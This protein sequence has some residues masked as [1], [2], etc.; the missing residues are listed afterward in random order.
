MAIFG[1]ILKPVNPTPQSF[2]MDMDSDSDAGKTH[3]VSARKRQRIVIS[4]DESDSHAD[5]PLVIEDDDTPPPPDS[6]SMCTTPDEPPSATRPK[7]LVQTKLW[8]SG[9]KPVVDLSEQPTT[10][11][12]HSFF[13]PRAA[14]SS[15]T[16]KSSP[17]TTTTQPRRP[18]LHKTASQNPLAQHTLFQ[19]RSD[20]PST[21][22]APQRVFGI[23]QPRSA[24]STRKQPPSSSER[25]AAKRAKKNDDDDEDFVMEAESSDDAASIVDEDDFVV[26]DSDSD[27]GP[28]SSKKPKPKVSRAGAAAKGQRWVP[29]FRQNRKT[30]RIEHCPTEAQASE[31]ARESERKGKAKLWPPISD[32]GQIYA[33]IVDRMPEALLKPLAQTLSGQGRALRVATMCSGTESPLLALELISRAVE[34]KWGIQMGVEHV[35]SC[36]IEP[37]KQAYIERNFR[38]PLLFRDVTELGNAQAH[39]AYGALV[40]VPGDIDLLVAGTSCV[41]YSGLNNKKKAMNE[42]GESGRTFFGMLEWVKRHQPAIVILENVKSAPWEGVGQY[43]EEI[44]YDSAYSTRFDTKNYYIPQTRQRGYFFASRNTQGDYPANWH[45]LVT[46]LQRPASSPIEAFMLSNSD[47]RIQTARAKLGYEQAGKSRSTIDWSK[48][49]GR[50]EEARGLEKLGQARPFTAWEEGGSCLMSHGAWN[51]FARPQPERVLDLMDITVLRDAARAEDPHFKSRVWE[52]S[53]NVDRNIVATIPGIT[54]CLTPSGMPYL[55][56]RGGPV[57]G[58]EALSLQGLPIDEL[59]LTRES[60]DQLQN[61]A[62]NAMTSTV[63]GICLL[64]ALVLARKDLE[65]DRVTQNDRVTRIEATSKRHRQAVAISGSRS[66]SKDQVPYDLTSM[67][68]ISMPHLLSAAAK[69]SQLCMCEGAA[70]FK[71]DIYRCQ[72]C[73]YTVCGSCRSRPTH[74]LTIDSTAQQ[75]LRESPRAFEDTLKGALPMR[76]QLSS[77]QSSVSASLD[78]AMADAVPMDGRETKRWLSRVAEVLEGVEFRFSHLQR[79]R[80]WTAKYHSF[81]SR[82]EL[83]LDREDPHWKIYVSAR[84]D[85]PEGSVLRELFEQPVARLRLDPSLSSCTL[86]SAARTGAWEI[87]LPSRT[88]FQAT[89]TSSGAQID[90]WEASLGLR[91]DFEGTKRYSQMKVELADGSAASILGQDQIEGVYESLPECG[92]A[93]GSLHRRTGDANLPLYLFIDAAR[94]GSAKDDEFVFSRELGLPSYPEKRQVIASMAKGWK[95]ER[96]PKDPTAV[97]EIEMTADMFEQLKNEYLRKCEKQSSRQQFVQI[98]LRGQWKPLDQ[99]RLEPYAPQAA[100]ISAIAVPTQELP[101]NLNMNGCEKAQAVLMCSAPLTAHALD[102]VWPAHAGEWTE[103]DLEHH[104]SRTFAMLAWLMERVPEVS[105]WRDWMKADFAIADDSSSCCSVCAPAAP[106]IQWLKKTNKQPV[107]VENEQEAGPYEQALKNR[108]FPFL[109]HLRKA[110]DGMAHVRIAVNVA[111]LMHRALSRLPRKGRQGQREL[112]WRLT[113]IDPSLSQFNLPAYNLSSN[114]N[115]PEA[116]TPSAFTLKLRKEQKRSLSWMLEQEAEAVE[117]FEEEEVSE[118]SLSALE[119]CAEGRANQLKYIRG[120]VI[121]DAVGYGK[122]AISL[123]LIAA[124]KEA[125][126][127]KSAPAVDPGMIGTKATLV[128][129]PAQLCKQWENEVRKFVGKR[130]SVHVIFSKNDL[131]NTTIEKLQNVDI[132]IMSVTVY[133]TEAYFGSLSSFAAANPLPK[134]EGRFFDS[135]LEKCVQ[136]LRNRVKE[137]KLDDRGARLWK[138]IKERA[139]FDPSHL[140]TYKARKR[141]IG[142]KYA[143]EKAL[144]TDDAGQEAVTVEEA[145]QQIKA[146]KISD[147]W[148]IKKGLKHW[149]DLS[150]PPLEAFAWRRVI[151]DEFHYIAADAGTVFSAVKALTS[152]STW[153]LSGTPKT[154]DFADVRSMAAFLNVHLGIEDDADYADVSTRGRSRRNQ[155]RSDVE[156]FR[157]FVEIHSPAWHHRR[158]K[159]AQRFL[160]RF[161]R[162]NVAEIDEIASLEIFKP[163]RMP[164]A[165]RACYLEL[166]HTIEA[167]DLRHA[168][169]LFRGPAKAKATISDND[170]DQRLRI[171]LGESSSPEEALSRQAAHFVLSATERAQN[172]IEACNFIVNERAEQLRQCQE[173]LREK[174]KAAKEQHFIVLLHYGYRDDAKQALVSFAKNAINAKYGDKESKQA[175]AAILQE[176]QCLEEH[177]TASKGRQL[178]PKDKLTAAMERRAQ[179][180]AVEEFRKQAATAAKKK[181]KGKR[182]AADSDEEDSFDEDD[183]SPADDAGEKKAKAQALKELRAELQRSKKNDEDERRRLAWIQETRIRALVHQLVQLR[184]ETAARQ[185]SLR[186]FQN[187]RTMQLNRGRGFSGSHCPGCKQP[188][189][190]K[191]LSLSSVCGH[192]FCET[193]GRQEAWKGKCP[194]AGC[195]ADAKPSSIVLASSLGVENEQVSAFGEKMSQLSYL[196]R[197]YRYIPKEDRVIL[198][199]QYEGL[200]G[201]TA[202]ALSSYGIKFTRVQGNAKK[203]SQ[204]LD[205]YQNGISPRVL[206]LDIADESAAGSNLTI[207]NHVIFLSSFVTDDQA[208][209]QSTL[210][211]AKGRC[212]RFGQTKEVHIW[213]L[214]AR[215][216]IDEEMFEKRENRGTLDSVL[217]NRSNRQEKLGKQIDVRTNEEKEAAARKKA[218][219]SRND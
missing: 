1:R 127:S 38:P 196:L 78:K 142:E 57:T 173:E 202:H 50:H 45:S 32:L 95:P 24:S 73:D 92:Q 207:A 123:A 89:I 25:P 138:S 177:L 34:A 109:L 86:L 113:R 131:N 75:G 41:D 159:I 36:E 74:N 102:T 191:S 82:L 20:T 103:I 216:T 97:D 90:S 210:Q 16:A 69:S 39:T 111:T 55:T 116:P 106:S 158:Q 49:Q 150:C 104:A 59:L 10:H 155:A 153:V 84:E 63:V 17:A 117:P 93:N 101:I 213:Q 13:A 64:S 12:I 172:A 193:C 107:P 189:T 151:I 183:D 35:F 165:E 76:L 80:V 146:E 214:L 194:E 91:G 166:Q 62:G 2:A 203:R 134:N 54:G 171:T 149:T 26:D 128:I 67:E 37:F 119:W 121:A 125:E 65:K 188:L 184:N 108:P 96:A 167:L 81:A 160:D 28:S 209:Y 85:E 110:D 68:E 145:W 197:D 5:S 152:Q 192:I 204:T 14:S 33:D 87:N 124:Q 144:E 71:E 31:L 83:V 56:S 205:D 185:R 174:I 72:S 43:F 112:T 217:A 190:D 88:R 195:N 208:T 29:A 169:T 27:A 198:F 141:A 187:I 19:T 100:G 15:I 18:S 180:A 60:D 53:Q 98:T 199:V 148:G 161:V 206:L 139:D 181:G 4:D 178:Y 7:N 168:R 114:R 130:L 23:F 179:A 137:L 44:N 157:N 122:T 8:A 136:A 58:L 140:T 201:K 135:A 118:A 126:R 143:R 11:R 176:S 219:K 129:V 212:L 66:L 99:V 105:A 182:K 132:V 51:E 77:G 42:G 21:P 156:R 115:D 175:V 147:V 30:R 40:D 133:K 70:G 22:Q 164:A 215:S 120:G 154:G 94:Y 162:Q 186:Y 200:L 47:Q 211:Q 79:L 9:A 218:E 46:S 3:S 61:L 48:C 6:S 170:R 163:V 52:L